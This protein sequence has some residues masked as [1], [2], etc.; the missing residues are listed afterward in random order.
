MPYGG[1]ADVAAYDKVHQH[2]L[3]MSDMLAQGITKQ[4]PARFR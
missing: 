2:I 4:F 3:H 1:W